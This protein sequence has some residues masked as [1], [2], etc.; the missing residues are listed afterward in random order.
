MLKFEHCFFLGNVCESLTQPL[1]SGSW[2]F[3][4]KA[5]FLHMAVLSYSCKSSGTNQDLE[6]LSLHTHIHTQIHAHLH[7]QIHAHI[8][9]QIHT[10]IHL[11]KLYTT[12][13]FPWNELG[14]FFFSTSTIYFSIR[15]FHHLLFPLS[16]QFKEIQLDLVSS[17]LSQLVVKL[18]A[19]VV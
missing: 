8:H 17:A 14:V 18:S 3:L 13:I 6:I 15:A 12:C 19:A 5:S 9:T 10:H 11:Y 7:T 2:K 4:R 1:L 16:C